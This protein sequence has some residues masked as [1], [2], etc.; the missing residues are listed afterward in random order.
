M[1]GLDLSE[2]F[3]NEHGSRMIADQFDSYADRIAVGLVGPGSECFGFDDDISRDHDWGPDFCM[4]LTSEDFKIVGQDFQS[5]YNK[6]P[7]TFMGFGPRRVSPGEQGRTGAIE[8]KA[9]YRTYTGLDHMP[10]DPLEW[11]R[12]PEQALATCTNGKIFSD[13]LGKFT[14]WREELLKFYPEDIRLKKIASRCITAAQAGQYNFERSVKRKDYF[15]TRYSESVF[16]ADIISLVFLL[17]KRYTP[18]YKWMHHALKELPIVGETIHR[19]ITDLIEEEDNRNKSNI[20]EK[21]CAEIIRELKAQGITDSNSNFLLD[22]AQSIHSRIKDPA[23][24]KRLSVI[25]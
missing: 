8:I 4:W 10:K 6:L 25:N 21:I 1:K 23:F 19:R 5:A 24:G 17:N 18:F 22:H 16:C 13:P 11:L 7:K 15:A 3:Y 12:I 2:T 14:R 9:F 20:I